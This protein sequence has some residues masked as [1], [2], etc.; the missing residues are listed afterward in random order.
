MKTAFKFII[1]TALAD[2][3]L[4]GTI[5]K[6]KKLVGWYSAEVPA[7]WKV[8]QIDFKPDMLSESKA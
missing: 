2:G 7:D 6:G 3:T 4:D 1:L 5:S 8:L